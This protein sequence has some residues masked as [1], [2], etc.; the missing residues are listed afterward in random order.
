M[1]RLSYLILA[2]ALCACA[3]KP[4]API[5]RI[6][7]GNLSLSEVRT[8]TNRFVDSEVRWGGSIVKVENKAKNTLVEIVQRPLGKN[9]KPN[10]NHASAGRFIARFRG[11]V[12]PVVYEKGRLLT[13][14]GQID[15]E[16]A[17]PIGEFNY[18]F[19]LV[20]VSS[21][22]LWPKEV[23]QEQRNIYPPWWYYDP[24]PYYY[25]PHLHHHHYD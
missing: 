6:P 10:I 11:F 20:T 7:V 22:Y 2:I 16:I 17:R 12:D 15:S 8:N 9:G 18:S 13:I 21:S 3:S 23:K 14:I 4:P 24:W 5:E 25:R 19:P 1:R